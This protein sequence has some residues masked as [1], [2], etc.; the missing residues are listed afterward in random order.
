M[1]E[2]DFYVG[3]GSR[4]KPCHRAKVTERRVENI[5]AVREYDRD[6]GNAP[7][8]VAAR[9]AYSQT[10][11]GKVAHLRASRKYW[12]MFPERRKAAHAVS[13]AVRD[14]RITPQLCWVCGEQAE[15][16]HPDY[17]SPLDVVWLCSKHHQEVHTEQGELL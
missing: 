8:R 12:E 13:N 7:H 15:A 2:G 5:E 9:K 16:H 6:R 11:A 3:V 4:C 10:E 1:Q 17:S 14:G